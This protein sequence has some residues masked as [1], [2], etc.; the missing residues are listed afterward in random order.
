MSL[1]SHYGFVLVGEWTKRE[2]IKSGVAY[3]LTALASERVV[4]SFVVNDA[5][6]YI[7][8]C[9]KHSTTLKDRM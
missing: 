4:Y 7:G 2:A 9:E 3:K 8:I 1:L 6:M 5:P